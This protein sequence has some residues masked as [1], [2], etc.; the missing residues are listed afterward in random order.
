MA[1]FCN[2]GGQAKSGPGSQV[3]RYSVLLKVPDHSSCFGASSLL[4]MCVPRR[5]AGYRRNY[6]YR[7]I[8]EASQQRARQLG[9]ACQPARPRR[10][11]TR[12]SC[13]ACDSVGLHGHKKRRKWVRSNAALNTRAGSDIV[14]RRLCPDLRRCHTKTTPGSAG[15]R[16]GCRPSRPAGR[17]SGSSASRLVRRSQPLSLPAASFASRLVRRSQPLCPLRC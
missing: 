1:G 11:R 10:H 16:S 2:R 14:K 8:A 4:S 7:P 9:Q 17:K 5:F 15:R 13:A 3:L 6:R 12:S